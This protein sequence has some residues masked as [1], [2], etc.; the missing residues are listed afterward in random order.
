M[1]HDL[2]TGSATQGGSTITMQLVKN[3]YSPRAD[4][5]VSKKLEETYLAFQYEK[6]YT[7]NQILARYLNGVFYGQNAIGVQAASLTYFDKDVREITL[8]QA[9]L[10]AGLPQAPTAYNPFENPVAARAAQRGARGDGPAGVHHAPR[11][12]S[13]PRRRASTSSAARPTSASARSTSS[14]TSAR[15]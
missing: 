3:L 4:R 15:S 9:A 12:P 6:R 1:V 7:K 5:T 8:P 11:W 2:E 13:G 14:S 10:L